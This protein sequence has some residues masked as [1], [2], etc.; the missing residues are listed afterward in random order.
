MKLIVFSDNHRDRL[1]IDRMLCQQAYDHAISLGDSEMSEAELSR[2]G[3]FGVRGNYPF[4]PAFPFEL[5]MTF[6]GVRIFFTH[7]HLQRVKSGLTGLYERAQAVKAHLCCFGHTHQR[8]ITELHGITMLNPG[9]LAFPKGQVERTYACV[10]C[11][12]KR[13]IIDIHDVDRG[14][15]LTHYE[16][17]LPQVNDDE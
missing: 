15:I 2:K 12:K 8:T 5:T 10:T 3:I 4:E 6:E 17:E 14:V 7:G 9:S 16:K 13:F 1:V 11:S